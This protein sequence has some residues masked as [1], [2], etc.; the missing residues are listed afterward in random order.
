MVHILIKSTNKTQK[1]RT[2]NEI[3]VGEVLQKNCICPWEIWHKVNIQF[4][5]SSTKSLCE[6]KLDFSWYT[7]YVNHYYLVLPL[8]EC[9][10]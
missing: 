1:Q 5:H 10:N 3:H 9:L 2:L 6:K 4:K 7:V 8:V